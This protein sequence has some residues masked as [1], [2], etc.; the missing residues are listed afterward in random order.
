LKTED[1]TSNLTLFFSLIFNQAG[2]L[3][4]LQPASTTSLLKAIDK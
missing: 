1:K 3:Q 2:T 4:L